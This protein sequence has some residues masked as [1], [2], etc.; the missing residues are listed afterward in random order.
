MEGGVTGCKITYV[1][2]RCRSNFLLDISVTGH[3]SGRVVQHQPLVSFVID[4]AIGAAH[5]PERFVLCIFFCKV[6]PDLFVAAGAHFVGYCFE[7][8][9]LRCSREHRGLSLNWFKRK[10]QQRVFSDVV[11]TKSVQERESAA[12]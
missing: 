1:G 8:V 6:M 2:K 11:R 9:R 7:R 4:M 12:R 5:I 10:C 3:A